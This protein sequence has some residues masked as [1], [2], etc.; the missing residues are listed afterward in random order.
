M[1]FWQWCPCFRHGAISQTKFLSFYRAKRRPPVVPVPPLQTEGLNRVQLLQRRREQVQS[2]VRL[3]SLKC[4]QARHH[5]V[6][7]ASVVW[8]HWCA[9]RILV[10]FTTSKLECQSGL[11]GMW[12]DYQFLFTHQLNQCL[13]LLSNTSNRLSNLGFHHMCL[14]D[15][16]MVC[17]LWAYCSS[18]SLAWLTY[19]ETMLLSYS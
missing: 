14:I 7:W 1:P 10:T 11:L 3:R 6:E 4:R 19:F 2:N 15:T 18:F 17:F 8:V 5:C 13:L 16:N 9:E 12:V